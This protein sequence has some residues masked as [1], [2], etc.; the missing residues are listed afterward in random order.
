MIVVAAMRVAAHQ[1]IQLQEMLQRLAVTTL[2]FAVMDVNIR[3]V[4]GEIFK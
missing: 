1:K 3:N 4:V 2:A